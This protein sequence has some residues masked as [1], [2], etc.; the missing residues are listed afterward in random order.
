MLLL[1]LTG[2]H[3]GAP[4]RSP[5]PGG[6]TTT[7]PPAPPYALQPD[8]IGLNAVTLILPATRIQQYDAIKAE[9]FPAVRLYIEWDL[10]EHHPGQF[11]WEN[12][13]SMINEANR[14]G[15]KILGLLTYAPSW[16]VPP[17]NRTLVH[18]APSDVEAWA[19]FV[20]QVAQRYRGVI[21]HWEVWNEPNIDDSFAPGPDPALYT[22]MLKE[23][24]TAIKSADPDS[25]VITGGT[26]PAVDNPTE[27]SPVT[28]LRALY[29]HGA[30]DYF[31][32]VAMHPYSSPE[33]LSI[34]GPAET[35]NSN[36][37]IRDVTALM[38][39]RGQRDKLIWFTEFG[40]STATPG[41]TA[42]DLSGQQVGVSPAHQAEILTDG[43]NY[44]RSLPNGGPIFLFDHRDIETGS[45]NVEFNYGLLRS[46]FTAKP[47]LAAVQSLLRAR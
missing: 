32:A 6:D 3:N 17:Q 1:V 27:M 44:V 10:I 13:D 36:R 8:T 11:D 24:Y 26:S 16:S 38:R 14:R 9:G 46:D 45:R 28:F 31:D 25:T 40:A 39:S 4:A 30:G 41:A 47:S 43:I 20:A 37:A 18:P 33:L 42:P 2:C 23:A 34:L 12:T 5:A 15:L 7:P 19:R 35:S 22:A 29:D 21:R